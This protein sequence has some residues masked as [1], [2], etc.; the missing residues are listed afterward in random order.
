MLKGLSDLTKNKKEK[1]K[2]VEDAKIYALVL[3]Y[4]KTDVHAQ[5]VI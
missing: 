3:V 2:N 4:T 1:E 5:W